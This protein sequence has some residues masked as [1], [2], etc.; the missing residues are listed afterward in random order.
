M[1]NNELIESMFPY[2]EDMEDIELVQTTSRR[3]GADKM[4]EIKDKEIAELKSVVAR[5]WNILDDIDT[6]ADLCI[7]GT[8][9]YSSKFSNIIDKTAERH[10]MVQSDG[11]NLFFNDKQIV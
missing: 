8:E 5:L 6:Y 7:D 4:A 2:Y 11:Y 3:V 10:T 9:P 1:T